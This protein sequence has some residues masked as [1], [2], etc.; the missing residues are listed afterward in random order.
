MKWL[1]TCFDPFAKAETNSSEIVWRELRQREWGDQVE[2]AG[3]LPVTFA[4]CWP[5]LKKILS[6]RTFDGVLALGQA[7]TRNK[8][9]LECIALNWIDA[10]I[11]DNAGEQ[12][13]LQPV[14]AEGAQVLWSPVP[15]ADLGENE[16]WSR[17]YSAGTFVCNALMYHLLY[18]A[19]GNN[20]LGG[21]V[22]VPL[23]TDPDIVQAMDQILRYLCQLPPNAT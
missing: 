12:P 11:A 21:F 3:P 22:H 6:D 16:L 23:R 18:W 20:K 8:I 4:G 10:G 9:S 5:E 14:R 2:F 15:W 1:V 13:R 17:S 7:E 19:H